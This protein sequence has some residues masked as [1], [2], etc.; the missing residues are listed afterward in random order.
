MPFSLTPARPIAGKRLA[1]AIQELRTVGDHRSDDAI[2]G[3]RRHVKKARALL[4]L[5]LPAPG[6]AYTDADARMRSANR[7]LAP[8]ANGE[9]VVDTIARLWK[10]YS[11]QL[12]ERTFDSIDSALMDGSALID[13]KAARPAR[14]PS[15]LARAVHRCD[16]AA[17]KKPW[18]R[19][20]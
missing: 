20:A 12:S 5:V 15:V 1:L 10:R 16:A 9:A 6:K 8:I 2:H 3:A 4:R 13:R 7:L 17:K 14:P 11:R 18:R 19:A